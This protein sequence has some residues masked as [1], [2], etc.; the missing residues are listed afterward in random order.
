MLMRFSSA[1]SQMA[2]IPLTVDKHQGVSVY[3][4]HKG[5]RERER[6]EMPFLKRMCDQKMMTE[7][8][9]CIMATR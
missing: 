1:M 8:Q 4:Q 3:N 7:K 9:T 6:E 5:E 2:G